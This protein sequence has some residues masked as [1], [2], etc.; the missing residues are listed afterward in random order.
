MYS[1]FFAPQLEILKYKKPRSLSH[2]R[3]SLLP[4]TTMLSHTTV[5]LLLSS[6][7]ASAVQAAPYGSSRKRKSGLRGGVI[8]GIVVGEISV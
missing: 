1:I 4:P 6:L 2:L 8:G 7:M 5:L 3:S